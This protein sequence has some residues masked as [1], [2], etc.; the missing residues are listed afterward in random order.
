MEFAV[1]II[2]FVKSLKEKR[3]SVSDVNNARENTKCRR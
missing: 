3:E 1:S 2:N